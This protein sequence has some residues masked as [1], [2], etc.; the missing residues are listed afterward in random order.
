[1]FIYTRY[2]VRQAED[3]FSHILIL[4]EGEALSPSPSPLPSRER[5]RVR[6]QKS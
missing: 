5:V 2:Q 1:M 4:L 6:G 3:E